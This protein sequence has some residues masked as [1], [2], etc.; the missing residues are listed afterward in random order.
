MPTETESDYAFTVQALVD[1]WKI[2]PGEAL[3]EEMFYVGGK[4]QNILGV[5]KV[6]QESVSGEDG[7]VDK[8]MGQFLMPSLEDVAT[9]INIFG[10]Q[11]K[12]DLN[13]DEPKQRALLKSSAQFDLKYYEGHPLRPEEDHGARERRQFMVDDTKGTLASIDAKK[14]PVQ[15]FNSKV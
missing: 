10:K 6:F 14:E 12:K 5:Y 1:H 7:S 15:D 4:R 2:D 13:F 11:M 3:T 9:L 8:F